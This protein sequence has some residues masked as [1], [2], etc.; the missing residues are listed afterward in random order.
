MAVLSFSAIE[1]RSGCSILPAND[2]CIA[3]SLVVASEN[4]AAAFPVTNCLTLSGD[5]W[6]QGILLIV[7]PR[8]VSVSR[9]L[10]K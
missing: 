2:R 10:Q 8:D 4:V 5:G 3:Q 6:L 1:P 7:L 9:A